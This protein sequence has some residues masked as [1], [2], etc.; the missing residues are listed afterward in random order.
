MKNTINIQSMVISIHLQYMLI[1]EML[2]CSGRS[3]LSS[4]LGY[5]P[6]IC[7]CYCECERLLLWLCS[8]GYSLLWRRRDVNEHSNGSGRSLII[9]AWTLFLVSFVSRDLMCGLHLAMHEKIHYITVRVAWILE[10]V[11]VND[12]LPIKATRDAMPLPT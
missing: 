4:P 8:N 5:R 1:K 7:V 9:W 6:G 10:K 11:A 2:S 3:W 12:A